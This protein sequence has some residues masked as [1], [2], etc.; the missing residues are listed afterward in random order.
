MLRPLPIVS[1]VLSAADDGPYRALLIR[2]P[3]GLG[4]VD[5]AALPLDV[6]N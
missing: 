1:S 6:A 3:V 5:R 4:P 2:L